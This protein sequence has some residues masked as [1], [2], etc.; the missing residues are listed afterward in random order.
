M[1]HG[2]S[3]SYA[4]CPAQLQ[5]TLYIFAKERRFNC[6]TIRLVFRDQTADG[7]KNKLEFFIAV[8][9]FTWFQYTEL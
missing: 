8:I 2:G 3:N 1:P 4:L 6:E 5:H 7:I 9:H